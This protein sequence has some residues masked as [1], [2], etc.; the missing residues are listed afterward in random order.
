MSRDR[1]FVLSGMPKKSDFILISQIAR[2]TPHSP[3][4]LSLLV[5]K[6]RIVGK[7]LGRN[8][9]ISQSALAEYLAGRRVATP[10]ASIFPVSSHFTPLAT[11][12]A[13]VETGAMGEKRKEENLAADVKKELDE[14]EE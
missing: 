14:L 2:E 10:A 7:K 9:H 6:G 13:E 12:A 3:E 4:Y 11:L 5:R 1:V 8:W